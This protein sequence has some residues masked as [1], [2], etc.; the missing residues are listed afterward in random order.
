[1]TLNFITRN[2]IKCDEVSA[3]L[4]FFSLL[5]VMQ[6]VDSLFIGIFKYA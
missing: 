6:V 1:M 5:L 2:G 3:G 4:S